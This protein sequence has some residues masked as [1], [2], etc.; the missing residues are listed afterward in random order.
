MS[1]MQRREI[2][3]VVGVQMAQHNCIDR[4]QRDVPLQGTE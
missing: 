3:A 4:V 2:N 1:H